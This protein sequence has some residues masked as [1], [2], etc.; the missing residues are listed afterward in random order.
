MEIISKHVENNGAE[1]CS[2]SDK[3]EEKTATA[4]SSGFRVRNLGKILRL[5][6]AQEDG[7]YD[8]LCEDDVEEGSCGG[9][10]EVTAEAAEAVPATSCQLDLNVASIPDLNVEVTPSTECFPDDE[11]GCCSEKNE[12]ARS[13]GSGDS[14]TCAATMV[15]EIAAVESRPECNRQP[16]TV[17]EETCEGDSTLVSGSPKGFQHRL[18][19]LDDN[20]EYCIKVIRWL[21]CLG[22]IEKAFRMKFLTWF[23]LRSTEQERRVVITF[24]RTLIDEPSSLAGQLLDSFSEIVTC[25]RLRSGFCSKLWH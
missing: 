2:S 14:Q 20:Y 9:S 6:W 21:E 5:A 13:N 16:L 1:G 7:C 24:I 8:G 12:L 23:S 22:H 25:K 3:Q 17:H 19:Q 15:H 18:G 4:R 11:N 10:G